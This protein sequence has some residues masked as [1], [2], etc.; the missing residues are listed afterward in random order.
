MQYLFV[1]ERVVTTQ[2]T[3][4]KIASNDRET[5]FRMFDIFCGNY[6]AHPDTKRIII[7]EVDDKGNKKLIGSQGAIK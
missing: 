5:A 4:S 1:E 7:H 2:H 3:I 6:Y